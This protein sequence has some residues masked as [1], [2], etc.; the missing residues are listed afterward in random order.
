MP[1]VSGLFIYPVK[2]CRGHAVDRADVDAWGFVGDRRY[3]VVSPDGQFFT[4]RQHPRMALIDTELTAR[5]LALSSPNH[6]EVFI[7]AAENHGA[8]RVTVWSSTVAAEECGDAAAE[9]LSRFLGVPA[10]LVRMGPDFDR[11]VKPGKARPGDVV[12]FADAYPFL[13]V[14]ETSLAHLNDR[15]MANGGDPVPMDR[16]RPNLVIADCDPFAEDAW[17]QFRAGDVVFRNAGPCAR[18]VVT[19]T[20]QQTAERGKEPLKTL[21]T[22]RRDAADPT[23][24]NFGTNLVHETKHGSVRVGDDIIV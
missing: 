1:H 20:D 21:A 15:I 24:V 3:M 6:G 22:F 16:F 8:K 23:D 19:T 7:A 9:W 4:Q 12:T 5:G 13:V 2:S 14:G 17:P 18:C 11:P 10:R